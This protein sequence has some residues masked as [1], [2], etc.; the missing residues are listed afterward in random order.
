MQLCK[1]IHVFSF[2]AKLNSRFYGQVCIPLR[3]TL[4]EVLC[5]G[6]YQ[7]TLIYR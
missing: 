4:V 2:A 3:I 1:F 5:A 6:N 7:N